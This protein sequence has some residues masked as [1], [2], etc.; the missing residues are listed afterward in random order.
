MA[1][2][3]TPTQ[4]WIL[5]L[6]ALSAGTIS[7]AALPADIPS[8][9]RYIP[10]IAGVVA[11]QILAFLKQ[12]PEQQAADLEELQAALP[13]LEYF[14]KLPPDQQKAL[15]SFLLAAGNKVV[16]TTT[17]TKTVTQ[18]TPPAATVGS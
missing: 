13:Y 2:T 3:L 18:E 12:T 7:T 11:A 1:P 4:R 6:I 9:Y 16:T 14:A 10:L 8:S 5:S 17:T 15:L